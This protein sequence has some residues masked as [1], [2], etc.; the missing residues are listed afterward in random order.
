MWIMNGLVDDRLV[1]QYAAGMAK[2]V[3]GDPSVAVA[4]LRV[5]TEGQADSGAGLGAQMTA[6]DAEIERRGWVLLEAFT[7]AGLSGR[8]ISGRPGLDGALRAVRT[9][10]AGTL[11]VA[12]LDR[13]S[14]SLLDFAHLMADAQRTGYNLVALDL[15]VDL[16]QP[17]G[18][19]LA[20]VLASA[21]QWERRISSQRTKDALAVKRSE[22]VVLGRRPSLAADTVALIVSMRTSGKSVRAIA[23]HLNAARVPT[24][25]GTPDRPTAWHRST[26]DKVL[27]AHARGVYA[28]SADTSSDLESPASP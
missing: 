15:G 22:G 14:R 10:E 12:K 1:V 8:S 13:L 23:D 5:S 7:D 21:A 2:K 17:A 4:Y 25:H 24:A 6:I 28:A 19:F 27:Q 11:I 16:S 3:K 9:G 26:V 18:E 20:S